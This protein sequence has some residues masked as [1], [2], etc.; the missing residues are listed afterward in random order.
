MYWD[1]VCQMNRFLLI[2]ADEGNLN[3]V[4]GYDCFSSI[5]MVF[6]L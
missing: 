1:N 2:F 4:C 3:A 6:L 5:D